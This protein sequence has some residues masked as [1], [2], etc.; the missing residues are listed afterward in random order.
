MTLDTIPL[1]DL[2]SCVAFWDRTPV[3]RPLLT[4]WVGSFD[5]SHLY[6]AGLSRLP[7]G[8]LTPDA[9]APELFAEDYERLYAAHRD[10]GADAP[11]AAFP[12]MVLPWVEAI[13]GCPIYHRGGHIWAEPW[14]ED[15]A[16]AGDGDWLLH[17]GWLE[18][19]L[20]FQRWLAR[21][22]AG[23]FP[24]ALSLM[25]GP[26]D[27]LAA[28][29]GAQRL[30][31]DY[32]DRPEEVSHALLRLA[33]AWVRIAQAQRSV[34]GPFAGGY[35][36]SVQTL[37]SPQ[38]GGWF[39]DDAL[40]YSSPGFWRAFSLEPARRLARCMPRTGI[41]LHGQ[42]LY[43]VDDLLEI[44]ELAVIEV[45]LDDVGPRIAQ[46]LPVFQRIAAH[47]RLFV[48]GALTDDDLCLLREGLPAAGLA[49]Q[50]SAPTAEGA[51]ARLERAK[52]IWTQT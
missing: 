14:L 40:A 36:F 26:T 24:T 16:A 21:L 22:S 47:K 1:P 5:I 3:D 34:V 52:A 7:E 15:Y 29:R 12:V 44:P 32:Y 20:G 13:C 42:A 25:R 43:T 8:L 51:R 2:A 35:S 46:M 28:I 19:L 18:R 23:R 49:L 9:V 41:H 27:L 10:T 38:P 37:W 45:N 31:Y 6:P 39:Q 48:W 4:A 30:I 17:A 50:L 33:D 11:W